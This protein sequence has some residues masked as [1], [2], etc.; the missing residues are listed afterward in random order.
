MAMAVSRSEAGTGEKVAGMGQGA[1]EGR[2]A[3][4]EQPKRERLVKH[5][6]ADVLTKV[7]ERVVGGPLRV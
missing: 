7:R 4:A 3:W 1:G 6:D 5:Y 2:G